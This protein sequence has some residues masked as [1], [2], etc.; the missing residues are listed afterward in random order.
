MRIFSAHLLI[1]SESLSR[2]AYTRFRPRKNLIM[3]FPPTNPRES[4]QF[5]YPLK[6]CL[7]LYKLIHSELVLIHWGRKSRN[8]RN[9]TYVYSNIRLF[10]AQLFVNLICLFECLPNMT[11]H[12]NVQC[13][14][15]LD[16]DTKSCA[17]RLFLRRNFLNFE[18]F[19]EIDMTFI[20]R[21][22]L[23]STHCTY[24][25]YGMRSWYVHA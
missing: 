18:I 10:N 22:T 14:L 17:K 16:Y 5:C 24:V 25:E 3:D 6:W 11:K 15:I 8:S 2:A 19:W 7:K 9:S 4:F 12:S 21:K 13:S 23:I 1:D 20:A